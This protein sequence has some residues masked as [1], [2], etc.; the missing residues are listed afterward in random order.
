MEAVAP[1]GF[2]PTGS[3]NRDC[4]TCCPA[5]LPAYLGPRSNS[6]NGNN[7]ESLSPP[8]LDSIR[9]RSLLF[10]LIGCWRRVVVWRWLLIGR[11]RL[12]GRRCLFRGSCGRCLV[13]LRW[14][15]LC[16]SLLRLLLRLRLLFGVRG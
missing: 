15:L 3:I 7:R 13:R 9:A 12:L 16:W 4:R 5:Y 10:G 8:Y 11:R 6:V 14:S 1:P 2:Q